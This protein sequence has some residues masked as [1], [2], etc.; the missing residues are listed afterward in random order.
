MP[1]PIMR[2]VVDYDKYD[3]VV[4]SN[5]RTIVMLR[6]DLPPEDVEAINKGVKVLD[7]YL[8]DQAKFPRAQRPELEKI[9]QAT[10]HMAAFCH[11][12]RKGLWDMW[13][14]AREMAYRT[15]WFGELGDS[16]SKLIWE[17]MDF[18]EPLTEI[19]RCE[20]CFRRTYY[21]GDGSLFNDIDPRTGGQ[22][23]WIEIAQALEAHKS[24]V[25]PPG[26]QSVLPPPTNDSYIFDSDL[27]DLIYDSVQEAAKLMGCQYEDLA[28]QIIR[29]S[30][31]PVNRDG[32]RYHV[33]TGNWQLLA[34]HSAHALKKMNDLY[35]YEG[36]YCDAAR[37]VA[38]AI[39][40]VQK[41]WFDELKVDEETGEVVNYAISQA[42]RELDFRLA[43]TGN[44]LPGPGYRSV[45]LSNTNPFPPTN[46][47]MIRPFPR[48]RPPPAVVTQSSRGTI[49]YTHDPNEV[50]INLEPGYHLTR[51]D[52]ISNAR[53]KTISI[54]TERM[55]AIG[56]ELNMSGATEEATT[57]FDR[58][59]YSALK[60]LT[61]TIQ[62]AIHY[63][64]LYSDKFLRDAEEIVSWNV[65]ELKEWDII[66]C[67]GRG[68]A[69]F[70]DLEGIIPEYQRGSVHR[71]LAVK[72]AQLRDKKAS[73][74]SLNLRDYPE[75]SRQCC[76]N[77]SYLHLH[78]HALGIIDALL[79]EI[80]VLPN[81]IDTQQ[82]LLRRVD[83]I[84]ALRFVV[85]PMQV[86]PHWTGQ[87]YPWV[88]ED[89]ANILTLAGQPETI[90]FDEGLCRTTTH[91][92][93]P[94]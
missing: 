46:A 85:P 54:Y 91:G 41:T 21:N 83:L 86:V 47:P 50:I 53:I 32:P 4:K 43:D 37:I 18:L 72:L 16:H 40:C 55:K 80:T 93:Q 64:C 76:S 89:A 57:R 48:T 51:E 70:R 12:D 65:D 73:G 5:N 31:I 11:K 35:K 52:Y 14:A 42:A 29:Y 26:Y 7:L 75:F 67:P 17:Y 49:E 62:T 78:R 23:E 68:F 82:D 10:R 45:P 19:L 34:H 2:P 88:D 69:R 59:L 24:F 33:R 79:E 1:L 81:T 38:H 39:H 9:Y 28:W 94:W 66:E 56:E 27:I 30:V 87:R 74:A 15:S 61:M 90:L 63:P 84:K 58:R 22:F 92:I 13:K 71:E 3:Q 20:I 8:T 60:G 77:L 44:P 36:L 25:P 6:H